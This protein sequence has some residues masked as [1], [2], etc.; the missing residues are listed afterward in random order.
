MQRQLHVYQKFQESKLTCA[1]FI[2]RKA[3]SWLQVSEINLKGHTFTQNV[4]LDNA[5]L[6]IFA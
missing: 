2:W 5:E 3:I 6:D 1:N 4:L